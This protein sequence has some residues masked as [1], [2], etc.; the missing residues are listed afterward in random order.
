M[1]FS[2]KTWIGLNNLKDSNRFIWNDFDGKV[3]TS[4]EMYKLIIGITVLNVCHFV[5]LYSLCCIKTG[6]LV[7]QETKLLRDV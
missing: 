2:D 7:S 4:Y 1:M 6:T 5:I 3:S